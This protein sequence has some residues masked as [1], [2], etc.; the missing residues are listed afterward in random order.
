MFTVSLLTRTHSAHG[1]LN[2]I[3]FEL[4]ITV[5]TQ[6]CGPV[7]V[8]HSVRPC[9][10][11]FKVSGGITKHDV[12]LSV[13]LRRF[14]YEMTRLCGKSLT[15]ARCQCAQLKRCWLRCTWTVER[16]LSA[17]SRGSIGPQTSSR[18]PVFF[19]T[20]STLPR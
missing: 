14:I 12:W 11:F 16:W 2:I 8:S 1:C 9:L 4:C 7:V 18:T 15:P 19:Q 13:P 10:R 5:I 17:A 3:T 6:L 20:R